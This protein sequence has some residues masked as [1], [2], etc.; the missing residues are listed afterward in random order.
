MVISGPK[1]MYCHLML[2]V[3]V[4]NMSSIQK[5]DEKQ[6]AMNKKVRKEM[7]REWTTVW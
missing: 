2:V 3:F 4:I 7:N 5:K 1:E 6:K